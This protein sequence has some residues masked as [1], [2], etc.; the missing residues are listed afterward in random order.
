[1]TTDEAIATAFGFVKTEPPPQGDEKSNRPLTL[2]QQ[3]YPH[4]RV[5]E[6]K[7]PRR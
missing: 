4:L 1:M 6:T 2:A 5:N 7:G 3:I